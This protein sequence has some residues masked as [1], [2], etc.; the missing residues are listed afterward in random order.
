MGGDILRAISGRS[1]AA[2]S[3]ARAGLRARLAEKWRGLSRAEQIALGGTLV[4][5]LAGGGFWLNSL[6]PESTSGS[7]FFSAGSAAD[8]DAKTAV[9]RGMETKNLL[10]RY[11]HSSADDQKRIARFC[12]CRIHDVRDLLLDAAYVDA[13]TAV[14]QFHVARVNTLRVSEGPALAVCRVAQL[15]FLCSALSDEVAQTSFGSTADVFGSFLGEG[16]AGGSDDHSDGAERREYEAMVMSGQVDNDY[17]PLA[18]EPEGAAVSGDPTVWSDALKEE[19]RALWENERILCGGTMLIEFMRSQGKAESGHHVKY[20]HVSTW[21]VRK[22]TNM[23]GAFEALDDET[24]CLL[25][26]D[27]SFWDTR[28]VEDMSEMFDGASAF[29]GDIS[30]WDTRSVRN[31]RNMFRGAAVFNQDIGKWDTGEV[32]DMS[33]MFEGAVA[34][35]R[36]LHWNTANVESMRKMF[37]S[38]MSGADGEDIEEPVEMAFNGTLVAWQTGKVSDMGLMFDGASVFNQDIGKWD[39]SKVTDMSE[40][41]ANA[42]KF[43][44]NLSNWA[45][46][47]VITHNRAFKGSAMEQATAKQPKFKTDL[48]D[49]GGAGLVAGRQAQA[50][51]RGYV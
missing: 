5:A 2:T 13:A 40:M 29:D 26:A 32:T 25:I 1:R 42:S 24:T 48:L 47:A 10:A 44:Q 39:T 17:T 23:K 43:D 7:G 31:M 45:V 46:G 14:M 18:T 35:S 50:V 34:F 27:L 9:W 30:H 22:V 28:E 15:K 51:H 49:F 20:G 3:D 41:F 4:A 36:D 21:D 38:Q 6:R 12:A 8:D 19:K 16:P 37:S 33:G 11:K